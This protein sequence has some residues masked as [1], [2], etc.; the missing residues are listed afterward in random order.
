MAKFLTGSYLNAHLEKIFEEAQSNLTIISPYIKLH[1]RFIQILKGKQDSHKLQ[2]TIVFGK[3]S[4]D[5]S[6]SINKED[7]E[8]LKELPNIEIRHE[9]DLHAKYYA[10]ELDSLLSS[11]NLYDYSQNN[12]IEFGVATTVSLRD[13]LLG[14]TL[15]DDANE[16]FNKVVAQS[17]LLFKR[18]P[19]YEKSSFGIVKSYVGSEVEVNELEFKEEVK[20]KPFAKKEKVEKNSSSGYCIRTGESIPFNPKMPYTSKAYASWKRFENPDYAEKYC[21]FSG[22]D[23]KGGTSFGK[24]ILRKNWNKAKGLM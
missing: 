17:N 13:A 14:R 2:I 23:S 4:E 8:F 22:E 21:H 24:P 18:T 19:T 3:N 7:F 12:N 16:Y 6:K 1:K 10:N 5:F 15:D 20:R 9:P 11:M